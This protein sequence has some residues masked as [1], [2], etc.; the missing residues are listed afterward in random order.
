VRK[1]PPPPPVPPAQPGPIEGEMHVLAHGPNPFSA[2][3]G[4]ARPVPLRVAVRAVAG[5]L[6]VLH[7][8]TPTVFP[9]ARAHIDI[10][11]DAPRTFS[12]VRIAGDPAPLTFTA[13]V[14][15]YKTWLHG[16]QRHI[17]W[18]KW[19]MALADEHARAGDEQPVGPGRLYE[20]ELHSSIASHQH[21]MALALALALALAWHGMAWHGMAWHGMAWHSIA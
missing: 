3:G 12:V 2:E 10:S 6:V 13:D 16:L 7:C 9:L 5:E 4:F 21:G 17:H 20:G 19:Q 14:D 8:G 11:T 15:T 1:L 18:A